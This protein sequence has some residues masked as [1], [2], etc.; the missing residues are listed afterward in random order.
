MKRLNL[1]TVVGNIKVNYAQ[2]LRQITRQNLLIR[3][4]LF[5]ENIEREFCRQDDVPYH[6]PDEDHNI[7]LDA[8]CVSA[9]DFVYQVEVE[10]PFTGTTATESRTLGKI[11]MDCGGGVYLYPRGDEGFCDEL[12]ATEMDTDTLFR[13]CDF[14]ESSLAIIKKDTL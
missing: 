2:V 12:E 14:L 5:I 10:D 11:S 1:K 7:V 8:D 3:I 13:L 6:D 9:H 4:A